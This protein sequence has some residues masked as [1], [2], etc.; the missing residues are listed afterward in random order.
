[1]PTGKRLC[2]TR[3]DLEIFQL[4]DRYRFLRST[5]LHA[6]VGGDRTKLIERL[7]HLFHEG[8]YLNRPEQQWQTVNARYQPAVYELADRGCAALR[9][10]GLASDDSSTWLAKGRTGAHRQFAHSLMICDILAAIELGTLTTDALAFVSWRDILAKAPQH[11]RCSDNPF[12]IPVPAISY[13]DPTTGRVRSARNFHLV[14]DGLFGLSYLQDRRASYRFF[15]LE[16]DR[17]TV[18]VRRANLG[19]TSYLKK[20][21]AYRTINAKRIHETHLGIPNL[22]VLTVTS[23]ETHM[24]NIMSVLDELTDGRGSASFL[25]KTH[26]T[27][28][29][30]DRAPS[31]APAMLSE[32]WERVGHARFD[33]S[34]V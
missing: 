3:R 26:P 24:R 4:L 21:L 18:P 17:N 9:E 16:A 20:L 32:P 11:T 25:F 34:S 29:S 22:M 8:G 10:H 28:Q 5:F 23:N 31:P 30:F 6:F 2:L 27:L 13:T 14:P 33:I 19:Q 12:R 1:M 7:G 15:A